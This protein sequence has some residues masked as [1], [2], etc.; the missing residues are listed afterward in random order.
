MSITLIFMGCFIFVIC[1]YMPLSYLI[2]MVNLKDR[3]YRHNYSVHF[4]F[5]KNEA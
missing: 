2:M 4:E 3:Q 5:E 1:F